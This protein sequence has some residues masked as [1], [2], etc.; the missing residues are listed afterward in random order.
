MGEV[1]GM[2]HEW[3]IDKMEDPKKDDEKKSDDDD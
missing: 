1:N 3:D 2:G